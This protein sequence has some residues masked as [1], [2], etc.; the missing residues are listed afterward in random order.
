VPE[1]PFTF[2]D[3]RMPAIKGISANGRWGEVSG[4]MAHWHEG[5]K[6]QTEHHFI[7]GDPIRIPPGSKLVQ[8]VLLDTDPAPGSI[9]MVFR[10]CERNRDAQGIDYFHRHKF[11]HGIFWGKDVIS[12]A[13]GQ[14]GKPAR[15][16]G[17]S[18]PESKKWAKL[19]IDASAVGLAGRYLESVRFVT[20]GGGARWGKTIVR[21]PEHERAWRVRKAEDR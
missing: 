21:T 2:I 15:I 10:S 14:T 12:Y 16:N 20:H 6:G 17:G 19:T 13:K 5:N 3:G 7:G 18:L 4:R 9:M 11:A 1:K 8:E